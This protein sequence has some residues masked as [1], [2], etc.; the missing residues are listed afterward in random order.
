MT[1]SLQY[2]LYGSG[3]NWTHSIS[4]VCLST[5]QPLSPAAPITA[6]RADEQSG[7]GRRKVI[8]RLRNMNFYPRWL[9]WLQP[10]LN[11]QYARAAINTVPNMAPSPRV[12]IQP[13]TWWQV[14]YTELL[15]SR[16]GKS[17]VLTGIDI[18][19][20]ICPCCTQCFCQTF[21]PATLGSSAL[22]IS[23]QRRQ[24]LHW[25]V[26]LTLITKRKLDYYQWQHETVSREH[27]RSL[28]GTRS[29]TEPCD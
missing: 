29:T 17:F 21:H 14:D 7:L 23:R 6:Q 12:I 2:S 10:L 27:G 4:K 9:N 8:H 20:Q 19:I 1:H 3:L 13:A 15:P 5:S 16:K 26:W 24:I 18:W 11:A 25:L 28:K 22:C